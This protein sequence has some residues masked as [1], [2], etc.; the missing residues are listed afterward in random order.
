MNASIATW[1]TSSALIALL[2]WV[3]GNQWE[4]RKL[5]RTERATAYSALLSSCSRWWDSFAERDR[6]SDRNSPEWLVANERVRATR[7]DA[8]DSY[9]TI[10]VLGRQS[11][12][13]AA[14]TLVR[15][16]DKRNRAYHHGTTGIGADSRAELLAGFV[17][18]ARKDLGLRALDRAAL[19]AAPEEP[20]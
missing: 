3:T 4:R 9:A 7:H 12:V 20:R 8:W 19:K 15:A 13:Q 14:I 16:Y 10:Q 1:I 5:S 18:A 6:I 11:V 17:A 2:A